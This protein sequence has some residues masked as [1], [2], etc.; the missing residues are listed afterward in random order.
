L[1]G[2]S[3]REQMDSDEDAVMTECTNPHWFNAPIPHTHVSEPEYCPRCGGELA[4]DYESFS[5]TVGSTVIRN[6]KLAHSD[7]DCIIALLHDVRGY[8]CDLLGRRGQ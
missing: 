4:E 7:N 3:G 8:L 6:S 5:T 1:D 2:L